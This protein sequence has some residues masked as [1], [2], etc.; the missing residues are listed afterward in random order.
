M[1]PTDAAN[2]DQPQTIKAEPDGR[3]SALFRE[4]QPP[5][6][7]ELL[8]EQTPLPAA[9]ADDPAEQRHHDLPAGETIGDAEDSGAGIGIGSGTEEPK[10]IGGGKPPQTAGGVEPSGSYTP[11]ESRD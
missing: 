3:G 8:E 4:T 9:E 10:P 2:D 5:G 11:G 1:I 7:A 6:N